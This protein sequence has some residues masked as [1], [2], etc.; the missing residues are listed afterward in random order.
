MTTPTPGAAPVPRH[1]DVDLRRL[2]VLAELD[3]RKTVSAAAAALH[4][5]PSAVSQQLAALSKELGVRL[6][7]PAGRRLRL[8][9]AARIVLRHAE[10][11]FT[12]TDRLH[13]AVAAWR[14]GETGEVSVAGFATTLTPLILPAA[15][16]LK[17]S[18]PQLRT[19]LAE[20]DP[21]VSFE[22][23]ADGRTDVVIAVESPNAPVGDPRF[24]KFPLMQEI[25]D[26]A[27]PLGH[28]LE[29]AASLTLADLADE[30]WIFATAGM[31]QE[32]PLAACAAAGFT[33]RATHAIGDW[34]ATFAAVRHGMGISLV[35]RL[36]RSAARS[37]VV[38][39]TFDDA[40]CRQVFA[41]VRAGDGSQPQVAAVVEALAQ[42]AATARAQDDGAL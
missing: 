35:P 36:A 17:E 4:L 6:T 31:C 20:V 11:I 2:R 29:E 16:I 7:E 10:E 41:A 8:T 12:W 18:R 37:G 14:E 32:I 24:E 1:P 27:L 23:L 39:K 5:T 26:V 15:A 42:A 38:V 33:P 21:P 22:M 3:R 28:R 13:E 30:A 25:F 19:T 9:G 34:E 40:P